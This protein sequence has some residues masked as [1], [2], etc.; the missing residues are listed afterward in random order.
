VSYPAIS[1]PTIRRKPVGN[2]FGSPSPSHTS[3]ITRGDT[4]LAPDTYSGSRVSS[5]AT[6]GYPSPTIS[7]PTVRNFQNYDDTQNPPTR[8]GFFPGEV[9]VTFGSSRQHDTLPSM[10]NFR[11][12]IHLV[13]LSPNQGNDVS[14]VQA[15][16]QEYIPH[17]NGSH[18]FGGSENHS[19]L[20]TAYGDPHRVP[21]RT[22]TSIG[23]S[24]LKRGKYMVG[25]LSTPFFPKV[26]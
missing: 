14:R 4:I 23:S 17:E 21:A 1:R 7:H 8:G 20:Y 18:N 19:S 15:A 16:Q 26:D 25:R 13:H 22:W 9:T 10:G 2:H 12:D 3:P 24:W 5:I 11:D 6:G